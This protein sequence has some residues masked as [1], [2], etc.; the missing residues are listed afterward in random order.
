MKCAQ[1]SVFPK[2]AG[3]WPKTGILPDDPSFKKYHDIFTR[4]FDT[5]TCELVDS[6]GLHPFC[7]ASKM[8]SEDFPSYRDILR[9]S[10]EERVKWFDSMDEELQAL[11]D[12][13]TF[14]FVSRQDV[15]NQGEEQLSTTVQQR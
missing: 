5:E 8:Q 6:D 14:E 7:L 3:G 11:Y 10:H 4:F 2:I 9:M 12:G 13:G 1:H 15:V